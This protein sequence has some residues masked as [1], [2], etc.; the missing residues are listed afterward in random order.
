[1]ESLGFP[2]G[3]ALLEGNGSALVPIRAAQT[4]FSAGFATWSSYSPFPFGALEQPPQKLPT[5]PLCLSGT[6]S[7]KLRGSLPSRLP[8]V[9]FQWNDRYRA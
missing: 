5:I 4:P 6:V 9:G 7:G 8:R 2:S 1:M 3:D